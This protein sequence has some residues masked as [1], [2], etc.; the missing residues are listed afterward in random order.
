MNDSSNQSTYYRLIALWVIIE[1]FIGGIIHAIKLPVSGLVV[2]SGAL[3]C[4]CMIAKYINTKFAIVNA[5]IIVCIFKLMLSPHSPLAAYFAVLFQ[6][7]MAQLIF[8]NTRNFNL[9]TLTLCIVCFFES[10][11]QRVLVMTIVYGKNVWVA[12]DSLI[13]S[14]TGDTEFTRY[15]YMLVLFYLCV[16]II[17]G[18]LVGIF[19]IGLPN[20]LESFDTNILQETS[21][22]FINKKIILQTNHKYYANVF[23]IISCILLIYLMQQEIVSNNR[24]GKLLVGIFFRSLLIV[25]VWK[26]FVNP[27]LSHYLKKWL[28]KKKNNYQETITNINFILPQIYDIV[29]KSWSIAKKQNFKKVLSTFFI[30]TLKKTLAQS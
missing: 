8:T 25:S 30:L 21:N 10:G 20:K 7:I 28:L 19:I 15:S 16:H 1:A 18:F 11:I 24:I 23:L 29:N 27:L 13:Q 26:I 22:S 14:V 4:L 2:G 9:K 17:V 5:T 6:G 12:I 3:I